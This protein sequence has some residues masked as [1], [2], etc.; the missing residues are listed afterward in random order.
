[1]EKSRSLLILYAT[2]T[3]NAL[4]AA[5]RLGREAEKRGCP[6]RIL[7]LDE[8]DPVSELYEIIRPLATLSDD[9]LVPLFCLFKQFHNQFF[10]CFCYAYY[11]LLIPEL[12]TL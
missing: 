2:E 9:Y 3:G 5:E 1:M 7:S 8:F 11:L 4:D 12:L 6:I 10:M